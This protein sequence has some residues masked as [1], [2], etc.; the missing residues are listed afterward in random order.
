MDAMRLPKGTPDE[1][2]ARAQAIESANK[3]AAEVP[4]QTARACLAAL[5]L[6]EQ[7]ALKGNANSAS[8]AGV[9][10]L[11]SQAGLEGAALNVL[12]NLGSIADQAFTCR[13][14]AEV[15]RLV[16]DGRRLR[17]AVLAHV[18]STFAVKAAM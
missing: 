14:S 5:R 17:D 4:L 18:T 12:I 3:H 6:A 8:D 2:A 15:E 16:A 11:A 9:A 1:N 13:C 10:A 7:A